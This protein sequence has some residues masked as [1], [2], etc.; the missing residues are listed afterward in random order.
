MT[1]R[2]DILALFNNQKPDKPPLFSGLISVSAPVLAQEGLRFH[3]AH[4]DAAKMA[5]AAAS[6]YRASGLRSA[7]VPLDLYVEAEALGAKVD[8]R[9]DCGEWASH[10]SVNDFLT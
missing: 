10:P 6:T 3:E 1:S 2:N 4:H 9:E 5:R 8:F 7:A